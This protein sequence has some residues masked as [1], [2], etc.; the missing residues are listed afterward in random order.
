MT[1]MQQETKT[2]T[3]TYF[4][5][6][7]E[8]V[9]PRIREELGS[10]ALI[11]RQREGIVGGIGGFFGRKCVEVEAQP[12][13]VAPVPSVPRRSI[14]DAYDTAE[15]FEAMFA[16]P[17]PDR[18]PD[19]ESE[20][21]PAAPHRPA[22]GLEAM[23]AQAS[24][25]ATTLSAALA[26]EPELESEPEPEPVAAAGLEPLP[27][28]LL[29]PAVAPARPGPARPATLDDLAALRDELVA[30]AVPVRLAGEILA[31]AR[32]ALSPFD[33]DAPMRELVRRSLTR[34]IPIARGRWTG[35]RR[36]VVIGPAGAGRSLAAASLCAAYASAGRS[37]V[38]MSLEPARE[39]MRLGELLRG[40]DVDF[41]IAN[42][43]DVVT[44]ACAAFSGSD[45]VVADAPALHD[46]FDPARLGKTLEL[47]QALRPDETHLVLPAATSAV[48]GRAIVGSLAP[49][50]LPTRLI[51]SHSDDQEPTGVAVGLALA[52]RIPVSFVGCG[53]SVGRL[54]P[55][56]PD[57]LAGMVLR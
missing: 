8:D 26:A 13:V 38:A 46:A 16:A 24:P 31:E 19:F 42:A 53:T 32:H 52:N 28:E 2:E 5:D 37:V 48:N 6:S 14:V 55:A 35:R 47:L 22:N 50:R 30:A 36:I 56:E 49:H 33:P 44:R 25:F 54:R 21:D 12:A 34:R 7:L 1:A 51:V 17:E 3:K 39:A 9:L 23:L 29:L 4:G 45:I 15:P 10:D 20:D 11:V 41:E 57:R 18:E 43:P 27:S 40:V